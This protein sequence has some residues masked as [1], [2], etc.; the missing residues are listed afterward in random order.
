MKQLQALKDLATK[1]E[2]GENVATMYFAN[3]WVTGFGWGYNACN[4]GSL[5]AA[6]SLHKAVVPEWRWLIEATGSCSLYDRDENLATVID[7]DDVN[8]PARAWLLAIIK[9]KIAESE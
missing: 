1:V 9:A 4:H 3:C 5:D 8:P 7:V 6:L 2:A